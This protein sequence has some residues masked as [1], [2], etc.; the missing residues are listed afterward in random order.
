MAF[1]RYIIG[2]LWLFLCSLQLNGQLPQNW[3]LTDEDG[4]PSMST[5]DVLQDKQGYIWL[6][7]ANGLCRYDGSQ[8]K[9]YH[10]PELKDYE[11]INI[12]MD[13]WGRIWLI[14][15]TGQLGY[16]EGEE[17]V[18]LP[19]VPELEGVEWTEFYIHKRHIWL[20][21]PRSA[22]K[23]RTLITFRM[24]AQGNPSFYRG[25]KLK[26]PSWMFE[27]FGDQIFLLRPG[28]D[29]VVFKYDVHLNLQKRTIPS[30]FPYIS[31]EDLPRFSFGIYEN[32]ILIPYRD[33]D[34]MSLLHISDSSVQRHSMLSVSSPINHAKI[35]E[36]DFWILSEEGVWRLDFP[37]ADTTH[38]SVQKILHG[39]NANRVMKDREGSYWIATEGQGVFV[40]PN[41]KLKNV[42]VSSDDQQ[43]LETNSLHHDSLRQQLISGHPGGTVAIHRAGQPPAVRQLPGRRRVRDIS[44]GI[45]GS[46]YY[47]ATNDGMIQT[48]GQMR[49]EAFRPMG[50]VKT[51]RQTHEGVLWVGM[52]AK[53]GPHSFSPKKSSFPKQLEQRTYAIC[54][55]RD[56]RI[57]LGTTDGLYI[58]QDSIYRRFLDTTLQTTS[59]VTDIVET[60]SGTIWVSTHNHGIFAI[61]NDRITQRFDTGNGLTA[62]QCQQLFWDGRGLWIATGRGLNYLQP[63]FGTIQYWNKE[64]GLP[65]NEIND[66]TIVGDQVWVAT[67]RGMAHFPRQD[68]PRNA[69]APLVHLTDIQVANQSRPVQDELVLHAWENSLAVEFTGLALRAK[70]AVSYKYKMEGLD[71]TWVYTTNSQARYPVLNPGDYQFEVRAINEDGVESEQSA[72]LQIHMC[73]YWWQQWWVISGAV[74]SVL[75]LMFFYFHQRQQKVM[76]EK[77]TQ[78][79]IAQLK[80]KALQ[81]QMNPHFVFNALSAIQKT[82]VTNE[83]EKALLYLSRFAKLIRLIFEFSKLEEISLEEEIDFLHLYL[84]LEQLRFKEKVT[85]DFTVDP[86]LNEELAITHLP[87]LLLQPLVEN[88]FKHGLFHKE[89]Q[90]HLRLRFSRQEHFL[91]FVIEDNGLGRAWASARRANNPYLAQKSSSG[92]ENIEARLQL[93]NAACPDKEQPNVLIEDLVEGGV[94]R[95]TRVHVFIYR[96]HL[97]VINKH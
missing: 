70:N 44:S 82:L 42:M 14:N 31:F 96:P 26:S 12:E 62:N 72:I 56:Q 13:E 46:G 90:G 33:Q 21:S 80:Q 74:L 17:I 51:I 55:S 3:Q 6:A 81:L 61:Q 85:I 16:V 63:D 71:T 58:F 76:R 28:K 2:L 54:P 40:I 75:A 86:E 34:G 29:Y 87:P 88:A 22:V 41:L 57:W 77:D 64:D 68:Q 1:Y 66:V 25:K 60:Q 37:L 7:T 89:G 18:L 92:I 30:P 27:G 20:H 93:M 8:M 36:D 38:L 91:T 67:P 53:A 97:Q 45:D 15:I 39:I 19:P 84:Q 11:I 10:S 48:D 49:V 9:T 78:N 24:D 69:V 5:Y 47:I 50:G 83:Q 23:G 52:S 65:S 95:G 4:L 94:A 59:Y 79:R 35:I 32:E 43:I 73:P